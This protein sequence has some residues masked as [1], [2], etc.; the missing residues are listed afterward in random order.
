MN[1]KHHTENSTPS[2]GDDVGVKSIPPSVDDITLILNILPKV[3]LHAE[4]DVLL[5]R[6]LAATG[7]NIK[8]V[9]CLT[10]GR[11]GIHSI[12]FPRAGAKEDDVKKWVIYHVQ[13]E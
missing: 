3:S 11:I 13:E 10:P 4:R 6:T 8:G 12:A 2:V 7:A 1:D 9:I 5:L